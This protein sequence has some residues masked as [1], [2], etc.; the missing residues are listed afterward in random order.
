VI[1]IQITP[2]FNIVLEFE[3]FEVLK[4]SMENKLYVNYCL[5]IKILSLHCK[6]VKMLNV[7]FFVVLS[8]KIVSF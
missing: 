6:G 7:G 5:L 3:M 8:L 2:L 4:S 1:N